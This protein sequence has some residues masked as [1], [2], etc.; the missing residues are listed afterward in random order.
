MTDADEN[1]EVADDS[2]DDERPPIEDDERAE[3]DLSDLSDRVEETAG[4]TDDIDEADDVDAGDQEAAEQL[5]E[6]SDSVGDKVV[7]VYAL[8]LAGVARQYG[9]EGED[10]DL[11]DKAEEIVDLAAFGPLDLSRDVNRLLEQHNQ[12]TDIPPAAAV[13]IGALALAAMV[14]ITETTLLEDLL[15]EGGA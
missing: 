15:E 2:D 1:L 13:A 10:V 11:A 7:A 5:T 3:L 9:Q 12:P 4:R 6:T 8:L 14:V